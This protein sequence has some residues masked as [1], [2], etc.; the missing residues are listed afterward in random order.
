MV[1]KFENEYGDEINEILGLIEFI[2]ENI[3]RKVTPR[4]TTLAPEGLAYTSKIN[5]SLR[6]IAPIPRET[7]IT[8]SII[9]EMSLGR[10]GV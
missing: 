9:S 1:S 3:W 6:S 7:S 2:D 10:I 8:N 5:W 4:F